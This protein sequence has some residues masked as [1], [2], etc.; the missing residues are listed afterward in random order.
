M[1]DRHLAVVKVVTVVAVGILRS[2]ND[3]I[4]AISYPNLL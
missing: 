4:M 2:I 3:D 1:V